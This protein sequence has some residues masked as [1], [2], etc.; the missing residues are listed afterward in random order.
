MLRF[1]VNGKFHPVNVAE[2][3]DWDTLRRTLT[4]LYADNDPLPASDTGLQVL[5]SAA[6]DADAPE[7][8]ALTKFTANSFD[9]LGGDW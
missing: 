6:D 2:L 3:P 1:R 7:L 8:E 4:E 5:K 9:L